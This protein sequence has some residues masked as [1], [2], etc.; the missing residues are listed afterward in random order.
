MVMD[1]AYLTA[2]HKG[3]IFALRL[4]QIRAEGIYIKQGK[5]GIKQLFEWTPALRSLSDIL[6]VEVM[7]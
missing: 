6:C 7:R 3:G 2:L 1:L 4:E 5:T